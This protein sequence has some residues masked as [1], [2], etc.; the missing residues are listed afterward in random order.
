MSKLPK[1]A[2]PQYL[3]DMLRRAM[4]DL[5]PIY[6]LD[7]WPF[8]PQM[9]I[10]TST[11]GLHQITQEHSLPK[12]HALKSFLEPIAD[13]LDIVTMEGDL[14]KTWRGIFN[15]GFSASHLMNL[16]SSLLEETE[17]FCEI[18][19]ELSREGKV[20]RMKDLTD[21]LTMDVIGR[22]VLDAKLN[23]Q[24]HS[25]PLVDGLRMQVKWLVF[26]GEANPL[27]RFNP[28]RPLVLWY[29]KRRMNKYV[30]REIDSRFAKLQS[31][32]VH[33][34]KGNKSII[35]LV[36]AA[37]MSENAGRD[38]QVLDKT[39]KKF[40]MSQ[41]KLFLFSGHDTTSSTVCYIFYIL[42][43]KPAVLARVRAE[44]D[45]VL[46][47]DT[48]KPAS[49]ITSEPF[50]LNQLPY[51]LAVIKEVLR[52]Y[53]AVSS[54]RAGEPNFNVTDDSGQQF[55]T[56]GFLVWAN[57]QCIHRDPAYWPRPENFL[58]ER[59]LVAPGD[60]LHP[61]KRTWRPFEHGPRNCIGQELAM[62]EMKV[63]MVMAARRFE[64]GLAYED[65]DRER[66][67]KGVRIVCGERGYQIQRSQ[68]SDNLPCRVA[69]VVG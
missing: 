25:N 16:T 36:L 65:L 33:S 42:A 12:Y 40:T 24:K 11:R 39:F 69:E 47:S 56:D 48:S 19:Q 54:T 49:V 2:H 63:I 23:S 38:P 58:P 51:T 6:Y 41:I 15:P 35:D 7:I 29:N 10:V 27:A 18:L 34:K 1:D 57:S 52:L 5:G 53:P 37:Y 4:P 55:P 28:M 66:G 45:S 21:N 13:G 46:G 26:G 59:W 64:I 17:C 14:W 60:P 43:T 8:G 61:S 32:G 50:L 44:H 67:G 9:L 68:P 20:F 3:P 62:L 31:E 30:S 22:V